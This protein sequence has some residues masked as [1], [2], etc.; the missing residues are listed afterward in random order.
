LKSFCNNFSKKCRKDIPHIWLFALKLSPETKKLQNRGKTLIRIVEIS[1]LSNLSY[2]NIRYI[3]IPQ[4]ASIRIFVG[5]LSSGNQFGTGARMHRRTEWRTMPTTIVSPFD[6]TSGNKKVTDHIKL[7]CGIQSLV[8]CVLCIPIYSILIV[9]I[10][11]HIY[12]IT[13]DHQQHTHFSI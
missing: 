9:I 10:F 3:Y 12:K 4:V 7:V 1:S 13:D 5:K 11:C 6:E 2:I 8:F